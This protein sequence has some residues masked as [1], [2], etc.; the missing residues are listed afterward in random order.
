[1]PAKKRGPAS[2]TGGV[3][4]RRAPVVEDSQEEEGGEGEAQT[5]DEKRK[6]RKKIGGI[7][8][9]LVEAKEKINSGE[10]GLSELELILDEAKGV[11]REVKGTQEAMEDAKMFRML[12]Q[13]VKEVS[14]GTNTNEIKF[15]SLEYCAHLARKFNVETD[16][17]S[18]LKITK[19][20]L[21]KMGHLF[22]SRFKRAPTLTFLVGAIE[23]EA[24]E[25]K[26][27]K[28]KEKRDKQRMVATKTAIVEKSQT[29]EQK[30]DRLVQSTRKILE[31]RYRLGG[32]KPVD[33]FGFVI[34]P[35]SFG[36]TVENMF[37]VRSV[38][39]FYK[40]DI[41]LGFVSD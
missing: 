34:D 5:E 41:N 15:S 19:N 22:S 7:Y 12:C 13:V 2:K 33:Y 18:H 8:D 17:N 21:V 1:M 37:H 3:A 9:K 23:T 20:Q 35:D 38:Y 14:E 26:V 28:N 24:G 31:E 40:T 11:V 4:G 29:N 36:N 27:K 16:S 32:K 6:V 39:I 25:K 10:S 30:T